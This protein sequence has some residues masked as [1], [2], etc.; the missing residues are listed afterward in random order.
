MMNAL[1][2]PPYK[3]VD[4]AYQKF[5]AHPVTFGDKD[6][7]G[8]DVESVLTN[9]SELG[10]QH[11]LD[12]I[13]H[14]TTADDDNDNLESRTGTFVHPN[15][16]SVKVENM[17]VEDELVTQLSDHFGI[18]CEFNVSRVPDKPEKSM[19]ESPPEESEEEAE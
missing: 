17:F 6:K 9:P 11:S 2:I 19:E 10:I 13:F 1:Q 15:I 16:D 14:Y 8:N 12:Y 4:L 7:D 18:S 3:V 5:G